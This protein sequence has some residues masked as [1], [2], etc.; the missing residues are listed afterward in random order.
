[1]KPSLR[2][3]TASPHLKNP[4]DAADKSVDQF[5]LK[6]TFDDNRQHLTCTAYQ[7]VGDLRCHGLQ[8]RFSVRCH[9]CTRNFSGSALKELYENE[10]NKPAI[11]AHY[12]KSQAST[13]STEPNDA[14]SAPDL[15]IE[16]IN[17]RELCLE[18]RGQLQCTS[19]KGIGKFKLARKASGDR[20]QSV[21]CTLC[22]TEFKAESLHSLISAIR[23]TEQPTHTNYGDKDYEILQLRV[24]HTKLMELNAKLQDQNENLVKKFEAMER[25]FDAL[26]DEL[27]LARES[28]QAQKQAPTQ[29]PEPTPDAQDN[30][31]GTE[32]AP[33]DPSPTADTDIHATPDS[34]QP[35]STP[36]PEKPN[37]APKQAP[38]PNFTWADAAK[39]GLN[40]L[41]AGLQDRVR[42]SLQSLADSGFKAKRTEP[43]PNSEE[44]PEPEPVYF[45]NVPRGPI[46]QLKRSLHE[47][48]PKWAVLS[49]SFI[50]AATTEILCHKPYI[51][52]LVATMRLL[53]FRHLPKYD[54]RKSRPDTEP[55]IE[56]AYKAACYQR[57]HKLS[58]S[59][60]SP[61]CK[62]WYSSQA[63]ALLL[64]DTGIDSVQPPSRKNKP[65]TEDPDSTDSTEK[66][67]P[68]TAQTNASDTDAANTPDDNSAGTES[69]QPTPSPVDTNETPP[70][71]R[72]CGRVG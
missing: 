53:R 43:Q 20:R 25:K 55:T 7:K 41:P 71:I 70:H 65:S 10:L 22:T 4:I 12:A 58:Q 57:W 37:P 48:L 8:P 33:S 72:R 61:A 69:P 2:S 68:E 28:S 49:I 24:Q 11:A 63:D 15:D 17:T 3:R 1:M 59:S 13:E 35:T 46:G 44:K 60:R 38:K 66:D 47:C 64:S 34:P 23:T 9:S 32:T 51:P 14:S 30:Y 27:R 67:I 29:A 54:P 40:A 62:A 6:V 45:G 39:K 5:E 18:H 19:C 56:R 52:R 26:V 31:T 42:A 36:Q 16:S 21:S 50:G